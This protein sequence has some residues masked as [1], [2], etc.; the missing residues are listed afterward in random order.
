MLEQ[1]VEDTKHLPGA[2]IL[3]PT[4]AMDRANPV[5]VGLQ[6]QF[7]CGRVRCDESTA[8]SPLRTVID[9]W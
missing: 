8:T 7:R 5:V 2:C 6:E 1:P 9:L 3:H 4:F